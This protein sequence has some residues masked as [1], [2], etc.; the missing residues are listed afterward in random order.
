MYIRAPFIFFITLAF[1]MTGAY[2]RGEITTGI[3]T[4][5]QQETNLSQKRFKQKFWSNNQQSDLMQKS[6]PFKQ[7]DSHY[8]SLGSKRSNISLSE[9]KE[10]KRFEAEMVEFSTKEMDLLRWNGRMADLERQALISTDKTAR[11][12]EEKRIYD[13][14]TQNSK[15]FAESGETLSLRDINRFQFRQN[16]SDDAVPVRKAGG[17]F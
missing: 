13:M 6:F 2:L 16:R 8:S 7:W 1:V 10:K 14:V 5:G 11:K 4:Y 15:H 3:D 17:G 9:T 12:I